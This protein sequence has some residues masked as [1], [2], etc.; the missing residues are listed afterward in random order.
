VPAK[1]LSQPPSPQKID[2][3]TERGDAQA[4]HTFGQEGK[5]KK[6]VHTQKQKLSGCS[7][8]AL[9]IGEKSPCPRDRKQQRIVDNDPVGRQRKKR[10]AE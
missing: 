5:G 6:H 10:C 9:G 7:V 3:H 4:N 1:K 8:T 2:A